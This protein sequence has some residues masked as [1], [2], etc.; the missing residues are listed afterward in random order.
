VIAHSLNDKTGDLVSALVVDDSHEIMLITEAG[1]LIRTRASE[2]RI[3]GRNTQGVRIMKPDAGDRIVG[4][5]RFAVEEEEGVLDLDATNG[6]LGGD[7]AGAAPD[8]PGA[9]PDAGH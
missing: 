8:A 3:A 2:V 4:I 9:P 5:D 7:D 1:T 6:D